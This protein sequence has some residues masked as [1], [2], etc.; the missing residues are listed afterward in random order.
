MN[1]FFEY[2][3]IFYVQCLCVCVA[4][5]LTPSRFEFR[6]GGTNTNYVFDILIV[7]FLKNLVK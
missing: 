1:L 4:W 6:E 5:F 3:H 2:L 7:Q